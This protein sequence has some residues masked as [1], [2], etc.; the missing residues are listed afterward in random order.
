MAY[1]WL[2]VQK[3]VLNRVYSE[4]GNTSL[5]KTTGAQNHPSIYK[6]AFAIHAW[7]QAHQFAGF[8]LSLKTRVQHS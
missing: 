7:V 6:T 1:S 4:D 3:F 8:C 2:K 5:S